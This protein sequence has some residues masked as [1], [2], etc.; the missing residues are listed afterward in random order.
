[1]YFR[2]LDD[3]FIIWTHGIENFNA[4]CASMN[5]QQPSIKFEAMIND[6][7]INFLDATIFKNP[8]DPSRLLSEDYFK[9]RDTHQL[10]AKKSFHPKH[11]FLALSNHR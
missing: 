1:M 3:I 5:S 6:K 2:F 8:S 7:Q 11:T 4:F 9:K 10:L